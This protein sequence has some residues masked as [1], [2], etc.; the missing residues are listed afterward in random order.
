MVCPCKTDYYKDPKEKAFIND[1][2]FLKYLM[3]D[4]I[5]RNFSK[6]GYEMYLKDNIIGTWVADTFSITFNNDGTFISVGTA[7]ISTP[8]AG[9]NHQ[10]EWWI[11]GNNLVVSRGY[12][13]WISNFI[14][15]LK[16]NS[17]Y[18]PGYDNY[19]FFELRKK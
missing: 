5:K 16:N 14:V 9:I 17:I 11:S 3:S 12:K 15:D 19:L 13:K 8:F 18:F 7:R 1:L 2:H 10:G 4:P 6:K